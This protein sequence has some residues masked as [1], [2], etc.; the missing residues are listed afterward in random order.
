MNKVIYKWYVNQK[1]NG[2]VYY[3]FEYF[4]Y[5]FQSDPSLE[6]LLVN[7][8][9]KDLNDLKRS[10]L[11][12]YKNVDQY[13]SKLIPIKTTELYKVNIK[14]ALIL[15]IRTYK[16]VMNFVKGNMH[17]YSDIKHNNEK[18]LKQNV[19]FYGEYY[20]QT[21]DIRSKLR[22]NFDMMKQ[23]LPKEGTFISSRLPEMVDN[24]L[25][26]NKHNLKNVF[27]KSLDH[28]ITNLFDNIDT[29]LYV[30]QLQDTNNRIIPEAFFYNIRL[31]IE[32]EC[33]VIDSTIIRYSDIK[34]DG[35]NE[36]TITD[37]DMMIKAMQEML[38]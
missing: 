8:N 9:E 18:P 33:D 14:D 4:V 2:S 5:L 21:F 19:I 34:R 27:I 24:Q 30:H 35:L 3:A 6:F 32:E 12:K 17:V 28:S 25:Y 15:D 29:I 20:Y 38:T 10:F 1:Y 31:I 13:F 11:S 26:I 36:Y 23:C 16:S 37:D 7:I 22:L